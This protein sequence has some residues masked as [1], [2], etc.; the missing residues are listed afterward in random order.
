MPNAGNVIT[1]TAVLNRFTAVHRL[2]S[3]HTAVSE[4]NLSEAR[5]F[6]EFLSF[7]ELYY[8]SNGTAPA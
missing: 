7:G 6:E 1:V 4:K 5:L 8:L 2:T 3:L